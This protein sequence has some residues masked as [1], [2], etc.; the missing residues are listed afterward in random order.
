MQTLSYEVKVADGSMISGSTT[1][2]ST[3]KELKSLTGKRAKQAVDAL[4]RSDK[5]RAQ[6]DDR[7]EWAKAH[8]LAIAV[9]GIKK[10]KQKGAKDAAK[11]AAESLAVPLKAEHDAYLKMKDSDDS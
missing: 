8:P 6:N 3:I 9:A 1:S 4:I 2:I 10:S 5:V 11:A 7:T